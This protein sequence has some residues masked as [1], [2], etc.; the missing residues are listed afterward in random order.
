MHMEKDPFSQPPQ[1]EQ[2]THQT[3]QME[4]P[5]TID[6]NGEPIRFEV[7]KELQDPTQEAT[8]LDTTAENYSGWATDEGISNLLDSELT[9]VENQDA[10]F[11]NVEA[12]G[13]AV[14][15]SRIAYRGLRFSIAR[16]REERAR[17]VIEKMDHKDDVYQTQADITNRTATSS[18]IDVQPKTKPEKQ[19]RDKHDKKRSKAL[20][21]EIQSDLVN[22]GYQSENY[23]NGVTPKEKFRQKENVRKSSRSKHEKKAAM[24]KIDTQTVTRPDLTQQKVANRANRTNK[25][26]QREARQPVLSRWRNMRRHLA[27]KTVGITEKSAQKQLD[28]AIEIENN[29]S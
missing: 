10:G 22:T 1:T 8:S 4:I 13:S 2:I 12:L 14:D 24:V 21:R 17:K 26:V 5:G 15:S 7:E 27:E 28:K 16:V 25:K 20:R 3:L 9:G 23:I 6:L 18:S 29:R 11:I 19:K